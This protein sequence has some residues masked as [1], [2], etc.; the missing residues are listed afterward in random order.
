MTQRFQLR[1][2]R[3][4]GEF[5]EGAYRRQH[6]DVD[7]VLSR[8]LLVSA[9]EHWWKYGRHEQRVLSYRAPH[10]AREPVLDVSVVMSASAADD[11]LLAT[12]DSLLAIRSLAVEVIVADNGLGRGQAISLWERRYRDDRLRLFGRLDH[13]T[14]G[15]LEHAGSF[16]RGRFIVL[17]RD[18]ADLMPGAVETLYGST[19]RTCSDL[20][21]PAWTSF[22]SDGRAD[23]MSVGSLPEDAAL[24]ADAAP[25]AMFRASAV[26]E[27]A[28]SSWQDALLRLLCWS[29]RVTVLAETLA[30]RKSLRPA[31]RQPSITVLDPSAEPPI[32]GKASP[33]VTILIGCWGAGDPCDTVE[34]LKTQTLE[35]FQAIFVDR[36]SPSLDAASLQTVVNGDARFFLLR[37]DPARP[38]FET[39]VAHAL[40]D[41]VMLVPAGARLCPTAVEALSSVEMREGALFTMRSTCGRRG[42]FAVP[43]EQRG[44]AVGFSPDGKT[45]TA[46][47][48]GEPFGTVPELAPPPARELGNGP[49]AAWLS[50]DT[51]P[52]IEPVT[53]I[54]CEIQANEHEFDR[55]YGFFNPTFVFK[56]NDGATVTARMRLHLTEPLEGLVLA[57]PRAFDDGGVAVNSHSSPLFRRRDRY[58]PFI[59][60]RSLFRSEPPNGLRF[61][62]LTEAAIREAMCRSYEFAA[63]N[64]RALQAFAE[65]PQIAFTMLTPAA[66]GG[67]T[68]V[69]LRFIE[70]LEALGV[71]V[72]VYSPHSPPTSFRA[73][74]RYVQV[75]DY[76]ELGS[77]ITEPIVIAFTAFHVETLIRRRSG[78]RAIYHLRQA[79]EM[80]HYGS[81]ANDLFV[82]KPAIRLLEDL[83]IGVIAISRHV[84]ERYM[85]QNGSRPYYVPNGVDLGTFYQR[86]LR[87]LTGR[88][89]LTILSTGHPFYF[90]KGIQHIA[91]GLN[92]FAAQH[93]DIT[94][95]WKVVSGSD[96]VLDMSSLTWT[97]NLTVTHEAN[98]LHF[99]MAEVM[100]SAD[101]F[102]NSS[103]YE[104]YGLPTIEALA[105]GVPTIA[106]ASF[107]LDYV[108]QPDIDYLSIPAECPH[109]IAP[110]LDRMLN[111]PGLVERLVSSGRRAAERHSM[112]AQLAHFIPTFEQILGKRFPQTATQKLEERIR[113]QETKHAK[114]EAPAVH[115]RETPVVSVVIPS[116]NYD[117]MMR[118]AI[119]SVLQQ[120]MSQWEM[121][122]VDDGSSDDSVRVA[123]EYARRDRRITVIEKENGGTVS[124]L[125]TGIDAARGD[126]F[127]WLSADDLFHRDKLRVQARAF[128]DCSLDFAL[129][130][131][132]FD[133]LMEERKQIERLPLHEEHLPGAELPE[134]FKFDYIH[135]CAAMLRM[136][137]IREVGLF[138]PG[139]VY[140]MDT[141]M[142]M[143]IASY[144][145]RFHYVPKKLTLNRVHVGQQSTRHMISCRHEHVFWTYYYIT[146]FS[147]WEVYRYFNVWSGDVTP[148]AKHL[149]SRVSHSEASANNPLLQQRYWDWVGEGLALLPAERRLRI[150]SI[151][152]DEL[153]ALDNKT[154]RLESSIARCQA[155]LGRTPA[156]AAACR[157]DLRPRPERISEV[158]WA[159]EP[160]FHEYLAWGLR[161]LVDKNVTIIGP[162]LFDAHET[163][164]RFAHPFIVGHSILWYLA[165]RFAFFRAR[166]APFKVP[167]EPPKDEAEAL[168]LFLQIAAPSQGRDLAR[169]AD[170][171]TGPETTSQIS[172]RNLDLPPEEAEQILSA[173]A[174][175][176]CSPGLAKL[177]KLIAANGS[178]AGHRRRNGVLHQH[179]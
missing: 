124:A 147:L 121:V 2:G 1:V 62:R 173:A 152:R 166:I 158:D 80:F 86:E 41:L 28:A 96:E 119:E 163:W 131:S 160:L 126:Y 37:E 59:V 10:E 90:L 136:D 39:A 99:R 123:R 12:V 16:A 133:L 104:G 94:I 26:N 164:R 45:L 48:T 167:D 101:V 73:P 141:E 70:W 74:A 97:P 27:A 64:A 140:S 24:S 15:W 50:T 33:A 116:Y 170:G 68:Q 95:R 132:S 14:A 109:L 46:E 22:Y 154:A 84:G 3:G 30:I 150:L 36:Q 142:W 129:V 88:K 157:L 137:V 149:A 145:Y 61:F 13:T 98:I 4:G 130:Y 9:E 56:T 71:D 38:W 118:Q 21:V 92:V 40:G 49:P 66:T 127:C 111:E 44:D 47:A 102:I 115:T 20:T 58:E 65:R 5:D 79:Y 135:G 83:P 169:L 151:I 31:E 165:K 143:R 113:F 156:A 72:C 81:C 117:T 6:P 174:S 67:G 11:R 138:D 144:G 8:G 120:S 34:S 172:T 29:D 35:R 122:I 89:E 93:P 51:Y 54:D 91:N 75:R 63:E 134:L 162:E 128:A 110:T 108:L 153:L 25:V 17:V 87:P 52:E 18:G 43:Y 78:P 179:S 53:L 85:L 69:A 107:G 161:M 176:S 178:S 19:E 177:A 100:R 103:L 42:F 57:D 55:A 139:A 7:D 155:E 82:D 60:R 159:R 146:R 106:V 23:Q 32:R 77:A 175:P 114:L 76:D 171:L 148:F 105:S 125:N 112:S 168:S